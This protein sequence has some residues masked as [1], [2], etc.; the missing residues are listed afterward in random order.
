MGQ[1]L[2]ALPPE[3]RLAVSSARQLA[4]KL[5]IELVVTSTWRSQREQ[6]FLYNQFLRGLSSFPVAVPGTSRHQSGLAVDVVALPPS[7]LPLLVDA[8]RAS[9][10]KWAGPSDSVHFDYV[11]PVARRSTFVEGRGLAP[12]LSIL[13]FQGP[14][15]GG[16]RAGR[17]APNCCCL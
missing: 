10:F 12:T 16:T 9:G 14:M 3:V 7:G 8:M 15:P 13:P 2:L 11:L 1:S 5:G 17:P 6:E 4:T